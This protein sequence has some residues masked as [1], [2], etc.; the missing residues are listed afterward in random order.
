MTDYELLTGERDAKVVRKFVGRIEPFGGF[1]AY[2]VLW[3]FGALMFGTLV[4]VGLFLLADQL[5]PSVAVAQGFAW[6]GLI[7]GFGSIVWLMLR[8]AAAKRARA[9]AVIRDGVMCDA[10]VT[11]AALTNAVVKVALVAGGGGGG[12]HWEGVRFE[13]AG[14]AYAGIAPFHDRPAPGTRTQVLFNPEQKYALAFS[15]TGRAFVMKWKRA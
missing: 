5:H 15:P 11:S 6:V 9:R 12:V 8:W 2:G 13:H 1:I 4:A 3:M 7:G 14:V 10:H